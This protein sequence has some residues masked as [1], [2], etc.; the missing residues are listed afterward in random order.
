M[1]YD[2]SPRLGYTDEQIKNLKT[3]WSVVLSKAFET[4]KG[5][6]KMLYTWWV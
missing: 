3:L 1:E 6:I 4:Y 2:T 5:T